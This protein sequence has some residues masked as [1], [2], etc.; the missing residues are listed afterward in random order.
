M[1]PSIIDYLRSDLYN[2]LAARRNRDAVQHGGLALFQSS[3]GLSFRYDS[4][5][6]ERDIEMNIAKS[7]PGSFNTFDHMWFIPDRANYQN[8][9]LGVDQD[10]IAISA[11]DIP[12]I[13]GF[14]S[15]FGVRQHQVEGLIQTHPDGNPSVEMMALYLYWGYWDGLFEYKGQP[16]KKF[17]CHRD[18]G[19]ARV[20]VS[21][22]KKWHHKGKLHRYDGTHTITCDRLHALWLNHGEIIE[23]NQERPQSVV[24]TNYRRSRRPKHQWDN[25]AESASAAYLWRMHQRTYPTKVLHPIYENLSKRGLSVDLLSTDKVFGSSVDRMAFYSELGKHVE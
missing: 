8:Y 10:E 5:S 13:I 18:R 14:E 24:I 1:F 16:R 19:P 23:A 20:Y 17:I 7:K 22:L 9:I 6:P 21:K 2:T 15:E 25:R 12:D 4:W 3:D 11:D